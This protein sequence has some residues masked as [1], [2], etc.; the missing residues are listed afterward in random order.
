MKNYLNVVLVSLVSLLAVNVH[1]EEDMSHKHYKATMK[2][3]SHGSS[4]ETSADQE[5]VGKSNH[6]HYKATMPAESH[7]DYVEGNYQESN[8]KEGS[9]KHKH[10]KSTMKGEKHNQ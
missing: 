6:K 1:A 8:S 9:P 2:G 5:P 4:K 3:E 7:Q 10:Y